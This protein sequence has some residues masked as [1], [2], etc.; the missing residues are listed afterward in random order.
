MARL[1]F[2]S[3]RVAIGLILAVAA[4]QAP[5]AVAQQDPIFGCRHAISCRPSPVSNSAL[6]DGGAGGLLVGGSIRWGHGFHFGL[7]TPILKV[8][9]LEP[10]ES[11]DVH[12]FH[13]RNVTLLPPP[14]PTPEPS[15][16]PTPTPTPA[17]LAGRDRL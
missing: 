12:A 9:V 17:P 10:S 13:L 7:V 15:P 14:E 6:N 4:L 2:V 16:G 5:P 3:P 11:V 1:R 8:P